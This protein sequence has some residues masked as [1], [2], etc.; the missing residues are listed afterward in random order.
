MSPSLDRKDKVSIV[1]ITY[2]RYE[3]LERLLSFYE[4]CEFPFPIIVLDSSTD[5][6][7]SLRL[8][9]LLNH[10]RVKHKKCT[11]GLFLA[12]KIAQGLLEV[13]TA[14]C[15]ISADDDFIVPN[16]I[17]RSVAFLEN[18][19][20]FTAA[21][22]R[23]ISFYS[24]NNENNKQQFFWSPSYRFLSITFPSP[25]RRLIYHLSNY[26]IPTFYSVHRTDF[27]RL[28]FEETKIFAD[29]N[30]FS[31]LLLSMLALIY[32]K[33]KCLDVFYAARQ[34]LPNSDGKTSK[35]LIDYLKDGTYNNE[36][37]KF[38]GCLGKHLSHKAHL[39]IEEAKRVI[40]D[41][42]SVYLSADLGNKESIK[43][44]LIHKIKDILESSRLTDWIYKGMRSLYRKLFPKQMRM[45]DFK[46]F[47]NTPFSKYYD[48]ISYIHKHLL[49]FQIS[50]KNN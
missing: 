35:G 26:S 5:K 20:D 19:P 13:E 37:A 16:G 41:A 18:N 14:Y 48:E 24:Q 49:S 7:I 10:D 15:V 2:N 44:I 21:H 42:M 30:R 38:R 47:A 27:F 50:D 34:N 23:Y 43:N 46:S 39:D 11:E 36:Y 8:N 3:Y 45:D 9:Q 32:G 6:N 22:G 12:K 25:K 29:F 1:I 40:D 31:E 4:E 17:Y 28:I 33:M